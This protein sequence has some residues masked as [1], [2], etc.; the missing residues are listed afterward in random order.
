MDEMKNGSEMQKGK[1]TCACGAGCTCGC[2]HHCMR[3]VIW[4]VVAIIILVIVFAIGMKAGEFRNTLRNSY[5]GYYRD[6]PMMQ[7]RTYN[8]GG[9]A[10]PAGAQGSATGTSAAPMIPAQQ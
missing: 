5:G 8:G 9:V 10:V 3:R 4:W 7:G 2:G 1:T 6:Y